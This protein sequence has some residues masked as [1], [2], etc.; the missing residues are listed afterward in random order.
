MI[1]YFR[2]LLVLLTGSLQTI[3]APAQTPVLPPQ[4]DA[5]INTVLK[6]FDVP[7]I[8]LSIVYDGKTVLAKGYGVKKMGAASPV[9]AHTIFPIASNSK[10]FT[11]TALAILVEE[12]KI[13]WE[14]PVI[15]H[16]PWFRMS[17][18][19]VTST[20]TV[21]DLL[22]HH[23][24]IAGYSGD[25][26]VFPPSD[27]TRKEILARLKNI[28]LVHSF[29]TTYAY[30]NILYIAAGEI[31]KAASG[32]EWEDFIRQ[33]ILLPL[34]MEETTSRFSVLK[35]Q[36]N[37]SA[38]HSRLNGKLTID[39]L[40][41]EQAMGDAGNAAGG[42]G[43][44]AIDMGKWMITQLDS[45]LAANHNRI[46]KSTAVNE[47][48]K[49]VTPIPIPTVPE[50]MRPAQMDFYGYA[51]GFRTYNYGSYKVVGHGGKLDGFVSQVVLVPKLKLGITVL[52]NQE[53][54]AAYWAIIYPLLD[55]FMQ[56]P[57]HDWLGAYK[58]Q[59]DT[60]LAKSADARQ[61]AMLPVSG[62]ANP[63]LSPETL[64]GTYKDTLYGDVSIVRKNEKMVLRFNHTSQLEA[65][66]EHFQY[67]TY[68]ARFSNKDLKADAYVSFTLSAEGKIDQFKMKV[69]D[70]DSDISY[71]GL[72]FIKQQ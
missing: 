47:L 12:G 29:R 3:I 15:D 21:R 56:N 25:I 37:I 66:L 24:G 52:T 14:D 22:V 53:S 23:S 61:K 16:L 58:Q 65:I 30:D 43:S 20:I 41:T 51:L 60:A 44:T 19:W 49:I 36:A 5:Y 2:P 11:A 7:G 10:A 32:M 63:S 34:N 50:K 31:V 68:I 40:F 67:D 46:F 70:P 62:K 8:G 26:L 48:W 59:M 18:P 35:E 4:L 54:T 28:P 27:Y 57:P 9:D 1:K 45:G 64:A 71:D 17:D 69:I 13:K 38:A 55:H 33:R 72:N 42:I 39:E 6:T